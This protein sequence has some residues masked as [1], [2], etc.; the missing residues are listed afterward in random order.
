MP[1][2]ER[3]AGADERDQVRAENVRCSAFQVSVSRLITGADRPAELPRNWP[4][5]VPEVGLGV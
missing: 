5:G 3:G 4:C 1:P 2:L